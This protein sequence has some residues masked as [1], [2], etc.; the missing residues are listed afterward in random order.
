M[1]ERHRLNNQPRPTFKGD[2]DQK[3]M[4]CAQL[5]PEPKSSHSNFLHCVY[6]AGTAFINTMNN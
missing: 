2:S 6:T 4:D 5:G 1:D 3:Q